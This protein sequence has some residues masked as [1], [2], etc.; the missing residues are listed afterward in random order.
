MRAVESTQLVTLMPK[1]HVFLP[2]GIR[3][4]GPWET[5][6]EEAPSLPGLNYN[7]A[8]RDSNKKS[9]RATVHT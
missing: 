7:V 4:F 3:V 8:P 2:A 5:V 9:L 6:P 1:R